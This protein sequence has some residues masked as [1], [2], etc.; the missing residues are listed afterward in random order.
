MEFLKQTINLMQS[1]NY[2]E[3]FLA[4]YWQTKIRYEKLKHFNNQIEAAM[5]L[6]A[7]S[8]MPVEEPEHDCPLHLLQEQQAAMGKYLKMLELRAVIEK[9]DLNEV[10]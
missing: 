6:G 7:D 4:E 3:R 8:M 10:L 9:I 1:E 2:K 5:I